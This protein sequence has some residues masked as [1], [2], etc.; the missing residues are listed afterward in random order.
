MRKRANNEGRFAK[1]DH[2]NDIDAEFGEYRVELRPSRVSMA[3]A[4][5][6]KFPHLRAS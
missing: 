6:A 5:L 3:T 4:R 1:R 2:A